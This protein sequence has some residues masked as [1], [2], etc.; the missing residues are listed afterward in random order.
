MEQVTANIKNQKLLKKRKL[1]LRGTYISTTHAILGVIYV[2]MVT[3]PT[4]SGDF[5]LPYMCNPLQLR[6]R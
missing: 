1:E 4:Y 2:V 6:C 3:C 5:N